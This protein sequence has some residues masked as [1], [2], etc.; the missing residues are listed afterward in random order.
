MSKKSR[1]PKTKFN[2]VVRKEPRTAP[3]NSPDSIM[4]EKPKWRVA[5]IDYEGPWG[6]N[7]VNNADKIKGVLD[8]LK[9]FEGMTWGE[10]EGG[11]N[12]LIS[13]TKV[14]KKARQRL[15]EINKNDY[16]DLF[17]FRLSGK[18]RIWGIR[19]MEAYYL[20]WWDP[21]HTVYLVQKKH[22]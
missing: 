17:S 4:T 11:E 5:F 8:K 15:V 1:K 2:P 21:K 20:L 7:N 3:Q 16:Q 19:E 6:F 14:C 10:I 13:I 18:E 22:T 12:H 9:N